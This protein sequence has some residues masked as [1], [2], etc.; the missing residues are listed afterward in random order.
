MTRLDPTNDPAATVRKALQALARTRKED[1][2]FVLN[3]YAMERLLY[4]LSKSPHEPTFVLKGAM[5]FTVWSGHP[6]RTTKDID[7]LG[8][9]PP[10]LHRLEEI[11]RGVCDTPVDDDGVVFD[12]S[13][14]TAERIKKD[15]SYEGVHIKLQGKL[16][17][18]RLHVQI[19]IGFGDAITPPP[20]VTDFPV[21]LASPPPR[22]RVYPRETVIA[23]KLEA[24]VQ[25]GIGNSRMKDFFDLHFLARSFVFDGRLLTEAIRATF[26]RRGTPIPADDP[27]ALTDT[28]TEDPQKKAQRLG[29]LKRLGDADR[30]LTF[31]SV[32]ADIRAFLHQPLDALR[33]DR[34]FSKTWSAGHWRDVEASA[35]ET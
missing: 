18:A 8:S 14:V 12:A 24:M 20:T 4:R 2:Q 35:S 17:A 15:A 26:N 16:G 7:L 28:F 31:P 3:R 27:V 29:F 9:G 33:H 10:A 22:L 34:P 25:L 19:D 21:L 11:F 30:N 6:H 32:V 5:L 1:F 23:E 13:S